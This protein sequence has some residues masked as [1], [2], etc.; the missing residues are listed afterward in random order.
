[1]NREDLITKMIDLIQLDWTA[2][3]E[4]APQLR[5]DIERWL[6]PLPALDGSE[7]I[8]TLVADYLAAVNAPTP[9]VFLHITAGDATFGFSADGNVDSVITA[10]LDMQALRL[11]LIQAMALSPAPIPAGAVSN[12]LSLVGV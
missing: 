6:D 8:A 2:A 11:S 7:D 12:L 4:D 10:R 9:Y 5:K 3:E 1:M